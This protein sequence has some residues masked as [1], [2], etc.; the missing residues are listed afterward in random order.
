MFAARKDETETS[1]TEY[2]TDHPG[3]CRTFSSESHDIL[4]IRQY[5]LQSSPLVCLTT[6]PINK[7]CDNTTYRFKF[8]IDYQGTHS[9]NRTGTVAPRNLARERAMMRKWMSGNSQ[10]QRVSNLQSNPCNIYCR[11]WLNNGQVFA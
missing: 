9:T 6:S 7:L 11:T 3:L 8:E 10:Q 1:E 2:L 5:S 4:N